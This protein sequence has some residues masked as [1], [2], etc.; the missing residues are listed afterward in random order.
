MTPKQQRD[1][2]MEELDEDYICTGRHC[3][4][5]TSDKHY[6]I[7]KAFINQIYINIAKGEI[8]YWT[9]IFDYHKNENDKAGVNWAE[10]EITRWQ[11]Q[12]N[13]LTKE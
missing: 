8:E 4:H 3:Q 13:S 1:K 9:E 7:D 2:D 11:D 6:I 5:E 12:L 10:V